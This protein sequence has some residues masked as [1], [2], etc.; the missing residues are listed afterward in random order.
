[1][2][3]VRELRIDSILWPTPARLVN[4]LDFNKLSF[5]SSNEEDIIFQKIR[6]DN[7]GFYF[8]IDNLE[9]Y[10]NFVDNI[11]TLSLI[12]TD[13]NQKN[14]YDQIWN[15]ILWS[16]NKKYDTLNSYTNIRSYENELSMRPIFKINSITLI[17]RS[18]IE[19]K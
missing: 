11:G 6:Y 17:I 18:I 16:I 7:G 10:F 3:K 12:F 9:I 5:E 2:D 13:N 19:K 8:K 14:E 4:L 1:M 15:E